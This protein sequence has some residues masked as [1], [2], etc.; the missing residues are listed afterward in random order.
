M[1]PPKAAATPNTTMPTSP[2]ALAL[3]EQGIQ[4]PN[5]LRNLLTGMQ[6]SFLATADRAARPGRPAGRCRRPGAPAPKQ[7]PRRPAPARSAAYPRHPR[8]PQ[9]RP[10]ARPAA[11]ARQI[12]G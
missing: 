8:T 5:G 10:E 3:V 9:K 4:Q 7:H 2:R 12:G 6:L 1:P 11:H